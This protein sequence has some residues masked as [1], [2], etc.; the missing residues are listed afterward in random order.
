VQ[1]L[2][3]KTVGRPRVRWKFNVKNIRETGNHNIVKLWA[4]MWMMLNL[5]FLYEQAY[6]VTHTVP[7][8]L[9]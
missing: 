8:F 7:S 2:D 9:G 6:I 3:G 1:N 4:L 5:Q